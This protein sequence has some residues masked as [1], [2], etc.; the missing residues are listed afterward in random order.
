MPIYRVEDYLETT[1]ASVR[2]QSLREFEVVIVD[3]GSPDSSAD[4]ARAWARKDPRFR[5]VSQENAGPSAARNTGI[6]HCAAPYLTFV[7]GDDTV[8]RNA[9]KH[10]VDTLERTGS[11]LVVGKLVRDNG[12]RQFATER[13]EHNHA[14]DREGLRIDQMPRILADVFPVNKVYRRS[15]WDDL[16][17]AFPEGVF[18]EDQPVMTRAFL[19]GTFD[20][21]SETVYHY[22]IR[23]DQ[24][25]TT[26][27]RHQLSD[28]HD[29]ITT[30]R[31]TVESV[32]AHR[33]EEVTRT[34]FDYVLPV[35]M[36]EYFRSVPQCSEEYWTLLRD[37]VREFW[38]DATVPF[39]ETLV[40]VQQR[41][42]GWFVAQDRRADLEALIAFLDAHGVAKAVVEG[43]EV[44]DHPWRTEPGIPPGCVLVS[45]P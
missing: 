38:N 4:I 42:M 40:P 33:S 35:D 32:L 5:V 17:L 24:S 10:L 36:W 3:D 16:G 28:L 1:L 20:V 37:A 2:A 6:G 11:D 39:E 41:L 9:W 14:V 27:L 45:L 43:V 44:F 30:K 29:R 8:P 21:L 31:M 23:A 26:Q 25:S 15:F 34:F 19:A 18:Y 22:W 12:R 7:D 13:M